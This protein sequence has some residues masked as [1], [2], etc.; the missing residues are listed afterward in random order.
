MDHRIMIEK[1]CLVTSVMHVMNEEGYAKEI[2]Q[3]QI[4]MKWDGLSKEVTEICDK[5]GLPDAC[6]TFV[7]REE[8]IFHTL[9]SIWT[10]CQ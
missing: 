8:V 4:D 6:R 10:Y 5:L 7:Q 2:L 3:E 9:G 1:V